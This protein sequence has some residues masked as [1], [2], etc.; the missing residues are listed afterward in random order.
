MLLVLSGPSASG[1]GTI[2]QAILAE[3]PEIKLSVSIT[4]RSPR[5]QEKDGVD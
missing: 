2:C 1:K 5:S 4:T 3:F